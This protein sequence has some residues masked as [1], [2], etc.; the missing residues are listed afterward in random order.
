M[1]RHAP[2]FTP[3]PSP[4][5]LL[6]LEDDTDTAELVREALEDHFGR[7]IVTH[8]TTLDA[9][10]SLDL[11][12]YDLLLSDM[13]LPDGT[14]LDLLPELLE[15]RPDLPVVFV[16]AEGILDNAIRAIQQ[17][18]YD[19]V[20]KSGDY[21]FSL[22]VNIE[23]NLALYRIKQE[24]QQLLRELNE[25]NQQLE[26][27]VRRLETI[28]ATDPLTGLANRRAFNDA[29]EQRFAEATREGH[30]ISL[31]LMDLDGFKP[32]NDTLGH[33]QGD[34]V[35][36][37]AANVLRDNCRVS[38]IAGRF[39]GDEFVLL[40]NRAQ[41]HDALAIAHRITEQFEQQSREA[42]AGIG[43]VGRVTMSLGITSLRRCGAS[44]GS[45]LIAQADKAMYAAKSRSD[46]A[47][48]EFTHTAAA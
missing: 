43:Y 24:N 16:T 14:G 15:Q 7:G 42:L 1:N 23:K 45:T 12:A 37:L 10:R 11:A 3:P 6:L 2:T 44:S 17:G 46:E 41:Y 20:V 25:K 47:V 19:Y 48:H 4:L 8:V 30:D 29:L 18:A 28:A 38:D 22:P 31:M 27:L 5:R 36:R 33:Q 21:L 13:N 35:L 40:L 9:A 34:E 32:L 26:D 39:G